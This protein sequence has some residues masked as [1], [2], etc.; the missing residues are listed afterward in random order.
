MNNQ[1]G[2]F[3]NESHNYE[4]FQREVS[5]KIDNLKANEYGRPNEMQNWWIYMEEII[6]YNYLPDIFPEQ[7][8]DIDV[9]YVN[10]MCVVIAQ[11][12]IDTYNADVDYE[13]INDVLD[14]DTNQ[15][16]INLPVKK[17][18]DFIEFL[19][20]LLKYVKSTKYFGEKNRHDTQLDDMNIYDTMI[21]LNDNIMPIVL[22]NHLIDCVRVITWY[23]GICY[24]NN[25][26]RIELDE[27]IYHCGNIE[28]TTIGKLI[29]EAELIEMVDI[30]KNLDDEGREE[31]MIEKLG[32]DVLEERHKWF[33]GE[34]HKLQNTFTKSMSKDQFIWNIH[35]INEV[36]QQYTFYRMYE[37]KYMKQDTYIEMGNRLPHIYTMMQDYKLILYIYILQIYIGDKY[38]SLKEY[39]DNETDELDSNMIDVLECLDLVIQENK[40]FY[41]PEPGLESITRLFHLY[42]KNIRDKQLI[43]FHDD[44]KTFKK[45]IEYEKNEY[46][47]GSY[48]YAITQ[49]PESS[50]ITMDRAKDMYDEIFSPLL[51][52]LS[53]KTL[54]NIIE[55]L[56]GNKTI[57]KNFGTRIYLIDYI[58]KDIELLNAGREAGNYDQFNF[59]GEK[60]INEK[61]YK[62]IYINVIRLMLMSIP[63]GTDKG[64]DEDIHSHYLYYLVNKEYKKPVGDFWKEY[65]KIQKL[66]ITKNK[67][68]GESFKSLVNDMNE[69]NTIYQYDFINDDLEKYGLENFHKKMETGSTF[70]KQKES[71]HLKNNPALPKEYLSYLESI[72]D[73]YDAEKNSDLIDLAEADSDTESRER[74]KKEL[75]DQ[76]IINP[77]PLENA[78]F[79]NIGLKKSL[80]NQQEI[81]DRSDNMYMSIRRRGQTPLQTRRE[82]RQDI[83]NV[84]NDRFS[85]IVEGLDRERDR[86]LTM[87]RPYGR[88]RLGRVREDGER[89]VSDDSNS[90][91]YGLHRL[92]GSD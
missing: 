33:Q 92:M 82:L 30:I 34:L 46:I 7:G 36:I 49:I 5:N 86:R 37:N 51:I 89:M 35:E 9:D 2:G 19:Q 26:N 83:L 3:P 18:R 74:K 67:N 1:K 58:S 24:L 68:A 75:D 38:T 10:I 27:K 8:D 47:L 22:Y 28:K 53:I 42:P 44:T 16:T 64:T 84:D 17:R 88:T 4:E 90:D 50:E 80:G 12:I 6:T 20:I 59:L 13:P 66:E 45:I 62:D 61:I 29:D 39:Y 78:W 23:I 72:H 41:K 43:E 73:E 85:N 79:E 87:R 57:I 60:Y 63:I 55:K 91:P 11:D 76:Y 69:G 40:E 25:G 21:H 71:H 70:I 81:L 14:E 54:I 77:P 56:I 15:N 52:C 32:I 31:L 65:E 48:D